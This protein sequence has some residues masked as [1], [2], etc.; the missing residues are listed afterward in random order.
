VSPAAKY[1]RIGVTYTRTRVPDPRI[2][3]Q[4]RRALGA[5]GTVVNVGAGAGSYE[6]GDLD[7]V[8]VEPSRTMISQ[9]PAGSSPVVRGE[10]ER[11]PFGDAT[12]DAALAV[13]TIHHWRDMA[14][15]LVEM[16]RVA[17]RQVFLTFEPAFFDAAWIFTDYFGGLAAVD[18]N[19]AG[20]SDIARVL[21]V[22]EVRPVP[23]PADCVDGFAGCYWNRPDAYLDPVVLD[24]ISS[25]AQMP[26]EMRAR[27]VD[28][29]RADLRSGAWD[30]K[31]G[32][33]RALAELDIG[34]RLV[35][36]QVP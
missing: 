25:F 30:H 19:D 12:F 5:A 7:V 18:A 24:G 36:A 28:R 14:A 34:Y 32:Y 6:P 29:L 20:P 10:A 1:D 31:Y 27:C 22:V 8:A 26:A 9:R 21:D 15:G 4:I 11:L 2:A 13:L 16:R 23:V 3:A 17:R 33:L 35:L